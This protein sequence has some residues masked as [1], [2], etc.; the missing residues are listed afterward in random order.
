MRERNL[1][2]RSEVRRKDIADEM[3]ISEKALGDCIRSN[4]GMGFHDYINDLRLAHFR[5]LLLHRATDKYTIEAYAQASGLKNKD[6]F[7][8]LFRA[9]YGITPGELAKIAKRQPKDEGASV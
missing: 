6:T 3:G 8:R 7:Y 2:V 4:T 1:Y 5:R 9:K